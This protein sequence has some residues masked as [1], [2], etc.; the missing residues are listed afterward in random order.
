MRVTFPR[1]ANR[2]LSYA[3]VERDDGVAYRLRSGL[4]RPGLPHDLVHLTVEDALDIRDGIW[5][6][7][8]GGIVFRSMEHVSGR[9]PP[10]AAERSAHLI[11]ANESTLRRA[12]LV[13]GLIERLAGIDPLDPATVRQACASGFATLL[14][15]RWPGTHMYQPDGSVDMPRVLAAAG[16]LRQAATDWQ[17]LPVG[18]ELVV[19]WPAHRR[20]APLAATARVRPAQRARRSHRARP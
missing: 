3:V 8:A 17:A 9:R 16:R 6:A 7:I 12:E 19:D 4:V 18:G 20:L 1:L 14:P 2:S 13:G 15:D 10:H 5:G 11:R